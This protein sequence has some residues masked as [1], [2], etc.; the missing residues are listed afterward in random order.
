VC[1]CVCVSE[2]V[3]VC[4][5]ECERVFVYVCVCVWQLIN[6]VVKFR[7]TFSALIYVYVIDDSKIW[8]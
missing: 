7:L 6:R 1:V 3:C 5:S 4:V 8:H 2:C